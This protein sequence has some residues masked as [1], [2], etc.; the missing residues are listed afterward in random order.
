MCIRD[1]SYAALIIDGSNNHY[2]WPKTTQMMKSYLEETG[3]FSVAIKRMNPS[4]LGIKYDTSRQVPYEGYFEK[5]PLARQRTSTSRDPGKDSDFSADFKAYD[6]IVLN[7]G[8]K[9]PEWPGATKDAFET[10]MKN[11]GGLVLVH[12]AN[13][14]W[15]QWEAY[16]EMI[17]LGGWGD[18][19][20]TNGPYVFYDD[21]GAL[22]KDPKEGICA[23]HGPELEFVVTSRAPDHPIMRGLPSAWMHTKDE[24]YA[25]MRGPFQNATILGT[26]YSDRVLQTAPWD[27]TM[28]GT[29]RHEAMLLAIEYGK[30]RVFHSALGHFDYSQE[31]VGFITTC[32][33][34]AEWVVTG[35]VTQEVPSDFPTVEESSS[36]KWEMKK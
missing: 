11:G 18:R 7:V 23:S 1:S 24:L 16:N 25:R 34:G 32:Q 2:I 35:A 26:A 8:E 5:Y 19:D 4:W 29:G 30:G 13:N 9:T 10:Y 20:S 36:R 17:G 6:L 21:S 22:Q 31:C 14:A 12:A 27:G 33:R 3:I 15:G 28:E